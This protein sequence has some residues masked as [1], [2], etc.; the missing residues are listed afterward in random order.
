MNVFLSIQFSHV[1]LKDYLHNANKNRTL[2]LANVFSHLKDVLKLRPSPW[3]I[4][5]WPCIGKTVYLVKS[6]SHRIQICS[7]AGREVL[8]TLTSRQRFRL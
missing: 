8:F 3:I 2:R 1:G 4:F 7:T 5:I 6:A